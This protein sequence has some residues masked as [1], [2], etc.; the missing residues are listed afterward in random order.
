MS[1]QTASRPRTDPFLMHTP[2]VHDYRERD[3]TPFAYLRDLSTSYGSFGRHL[4]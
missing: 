3:D 1:Q 4:K 2:S